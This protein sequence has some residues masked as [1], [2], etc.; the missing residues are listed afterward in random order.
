MSNDI[1]VIDPEFELEIN[2]NATFE[3]WKDAGWLLSQAT[4]GMCWAWGKWWETG[5]AKYD[6][7]AVDF[8]DTELRLARHSIMQYGR[9]WATFPDLYTRVYKLSFKHYRHVIGMRSEPE[10]MHKWLQKAVDNKWS[11]E[12][13]R[14][15]ISGK[16]G[17]KRSL[18]IRL[19]ET[20]L[21]NLLG[22]IEHIIK[23]LTVDIPA[24]APISAIRIEATQL[25]Q[26]LSKLKPTHKKELKND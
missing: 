7:K 2:P 18:K 12:D 20:G 8:V 5:H 19:T 3:E 24:H 23:M 15:A 9:V 22:Q 1:T 4:A 21:A 17:K 6:R 13:L 16:K 26:Q 14:L 11:S 10:K 25:K